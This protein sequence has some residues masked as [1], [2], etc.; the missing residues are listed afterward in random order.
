MYV[1]VHV[2]LFHPSGAHEDNM[3]SCSI[4]FIISIIMSMILVFGCVAETSHDAYST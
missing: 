1:H 2:L 4:K 3:G